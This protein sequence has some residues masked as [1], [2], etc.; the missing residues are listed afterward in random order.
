MTLTL[1][2]IRE[3]GELGQFLEGRHYEVTEQDM[4]RRLPSDSE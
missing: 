1:D 2:E 4:I 3:F